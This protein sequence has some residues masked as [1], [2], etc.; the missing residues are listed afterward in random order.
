MDELLLG[1]VKVRPPWDG[2]EREGDRRRRREARGEVDGGEG[3]GALWIES[4]S[5]SLKPV[6]VGL[7]SVAVTG[8][9]R[10]N[11][12]EKEEGK[13]C[14]TRRKSGDAHVVAKAPRPVHE[15]F[16]SRQLEHLQVVDQVAVRQ[17]ALRLESEPLQDLHLGDDERVLEVVK[18]GSEVVHRRVRLERSGWRVRRVGAVGDEGGEVGIAVD[19]VADSEGRLFKF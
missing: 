9:R 5:R 11:R 7:G 14:L 4:R 17:P 1:R 19:D 8:L 10:Q 16:L 18:L 13:S 15:L 12:L 2:L 6:W 3:E